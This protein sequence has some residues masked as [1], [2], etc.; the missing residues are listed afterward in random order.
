MELVKGEEITVLRNTLKDVAATFRTADFASECQIKKT[1]FYAERSLLYPLERFCQNYNKSG[2]MRID[3]PGRL[4]YTRNVPQPLARFLRNNAGGRF[5]VC[6]GF[7]KRWP[8]VIP[9]LMRS[10][11]RIRDRKLKIKYLIKLD[12]IEPPFNDEWEQKLAY[13][14]FNIEVCDSLWM[15]DIGAFYTF[16]KEKYSGSNEVFYKT[17]DGKTIYSGFR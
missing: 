3:K 14:G 10:V 15:S 9:L 11:V 16:D 13:E 4:N 1:L 17:L 7:Q 5:L 2:H 8:G 12:G 6:L